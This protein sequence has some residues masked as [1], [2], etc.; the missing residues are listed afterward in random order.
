MTLDSD[1]GKLEVKTISITD[2]NKELSGLLY[3][4]D[5]ASAEN[6]S[7]AVVIAHGIGGSK[8]MMSSLGLELGRRGFVAL[9][10]DLF[11]HG[12]SG[13]TV[14]DGR[15]EPSFGVLT[16]VQ[17]LESQRFVNSS[18]IGLVG[19]SLGGGAM[20]AAVAHDSQIDALVLIA[21]GLGDI[22]EGQEYGVLNSTFPKNLLVVVGKYDVLFNLTEL[23]SEK[24]PPVFATQQ[25]VVPGVLY[26][27][28]KSQ[29]DRK[30]VTPTTTHLF[31]PVDPTVILET[32]A[33]MENAL[34]TT[35][36]QEAE[37]NTNLI[38]V[39]REAAILTVIVG[40]FGIVFLAFFPIAN[41]VRAEPQHDMLKREYDTLGYWR[42]YVVWGALNLALFVPMFFV[43][44]IIPFPPLIFGASIAWWMLAVGLIGLLLAAKNLPRLFETK[45]RLR[46]A[47]AGAFG[48]KELSIA[49]VAFLVLF[50]VANL[51]EAM[52]NINLRIVS[53]I[54]RGF[55]S[56][57]RIFAFLTFV[58]FFLHISWQRACIFMSS[59]TAKSKEA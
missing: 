34:K 49:V 46:E 14:E 29:T 36:S 5:S 4:P 40:L 39:Q 13:G 12:K 2:D 1:F 26:G 7:A 44:F 9:C 22:A 32:I 42:T 8:E 43:G 52:L 25:G 59:I 47:L 16:A 45:I 41:I 33:W 55:S 50:A 54:F 53:P 21:G 27:S 15:N 28:F 31:E 23:A 19:H 30:L 56:G 3:R 48:R 11:G 37:L 51:L 38:Y 10:L 18:A 58:P 24:L 20:R 57:R 17:Y 35:Q 6:P